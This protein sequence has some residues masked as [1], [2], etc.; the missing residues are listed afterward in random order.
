MPE[1]AVKGFFNSARCKF[2]WKTWWFK[3]VAASA[4][5]VMLMLMVI[6]NLIGFG[7]GWESEEKILD[8]FVG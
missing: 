5:S 6:A 2:L 7:N 8:K 4:C 3:F 1:I